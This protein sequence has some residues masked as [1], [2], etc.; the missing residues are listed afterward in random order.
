MTE[1]ALFREEGFLRGVESRGHSGFAAKGGDVVCAAVSS[2]LHALLL[3]LSDVA[4]TEGLECEVDPE[5]P[6]IKVFWPRDQAEGLTL[7]TET[8]ALSL[9]EIAAE[10]PGHV[11]ITEVRL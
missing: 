5:V 2:L 4:R 1:V 11:K 9:G 6:L 7:L 3:G 8:V 10:N